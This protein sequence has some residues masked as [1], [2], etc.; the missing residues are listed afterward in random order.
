[1]TLIL[2]LA[3]LG[4][5][6]GDVGVFRYCGRIE[7]LR[8]ADTNAPLPVR[9]FV[10]PEGIEPGPPKTCVWAVFERK[11]GSEYIPVLVVVVESKKGYRT[12]IYSDQKRILVTGRLSREEAEAFLNLIAGREVLETALRSFKEGRRK[13]TFRE[14]ISLTF[15]I[16][17]RFVAGY[18][19]HDIDW[20]GRVPEHVISFVERGKGTDLR[21]SPSWRP[22]RISSELVD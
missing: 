5:A 8:P 4:S 3:V 21:H 1:M 17:A 16:R 2:L 13:V 22:V 6:F 10:S 12:T 11:E 19:L 7:I 15:P 20:S 9:G 18:T 14:V